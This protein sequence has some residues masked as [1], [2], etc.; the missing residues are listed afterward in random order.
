M[1]SITISHHFMAAHSLVGP[2]FGLA[3][4]LHGATY[5]VEAELRRA[6]LDA[7]GVICDIGHALDLLKAVLGEFDYRN[8]DELPEFRGRNT[9][10][11]FLAAEIHRR[12]ARRIKEG[13]LGSQTISSLRVVL[14]ETP[15][16]WAAYDAPL[17]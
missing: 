15:V 16:A 11:E 2:V 9:T 17:G 7:D 14:R 3:Q 1:Y 4:Q 12:L 8:L 5:V 6:S 13:G 10:T